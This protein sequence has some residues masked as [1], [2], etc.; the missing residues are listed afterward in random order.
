MRKEK[1]FVNLT[2]HEIRVIK[3]NGEV[4]VIQP[5]GL[6]ARIKEEILF[7]E[8][9]EDVEMIEKRFSEVEGLPEKIEKN[10]IYVVSMMVKN[11]ERLRSNSK[12]VVPDTGATAIRE[13]GRIIAVRR[14]ISIIK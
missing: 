4:M 9:V 11:T 3:G 10:A 8:V 14:F 12:F 7:D 5:S 13:N 6:I 2:P 1:K